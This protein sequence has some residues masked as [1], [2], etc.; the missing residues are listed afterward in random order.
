MTNAVLVMVSKRPLTRIIMIL[1]TIVVL[2]VLVIAFW[3]YLQGFFSSI[4]SAVLAT[5]SILIA[6]N[7]FEPLV[8]MLKPGKFAD[9]AHPMALM[10]L[11][12][13]V[14]IVLRLIFDSAVPGNVRVP[15]LV[16]KIGGGV[17]GVIV[18][19]MVAGLIA[20]GAQ[21]MPLGVTVAGYA[22]MRVVAETPAVVKINQSRSADRVLY[23]EM[24]SQTMDQEPPQ[25]LVIPADDFVVGLVSWISRGAASG[26]RPWSAIHPDYLTELFGNRI[27]IELG[28]KRSAQPISGDVASLTGV[29]TVASIP[30]MHGELPELRPDKLPPTLRP[31]DG[32]AILICRIQFGLD[33]TDTDRFTRVSCGTTRLVA[34][35]PNR[36]GQFKDYFPI[37]TV[38]N[39]NTLLVNKPD[40][41]LIVP[42]DK[43]VDFLFL[44]DRA[45][46]PDLRNLPAEVPANSSIFVESKRYARFS[47]ASKPIERLA[48][49]DT[50]EVMRKPA[51][52][53]NVST[54]DPKAGDRIIGVW[55]QTT[56]NGP[57]TFR[58]EANGQ[59]I[60]TMTI[61]GKENV[62][63]GS[64][65]VGASRLDSL[66]VIE[67]S[68]S[69]SEIKFTWTFKSPT[70][71]TVK[72]LQKNFEIQLTR[73]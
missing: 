38:A 69:G 18:G 55:V 56:A 3:H 42:A 19:L 32:Q 49:S 16:D 54:N 58:Y 35:V 57:V 72:D 45:V 14:Y 10:V 26:D 46:L 6:F 5:I 44:V 47:L 62:A 63:Q 23:D 53:K 40:D 21:G 50:V 52:L 65:K 36:P 20:V 8:T 51:V 31:E 9:S 43:A 24:V 29:Y 70:E 15:A 13:V 27:G 25:S 33:A 1:S 71:V 41:F 17:L 67:K 22:R 28:A 11:F 7:Y 4:I 59:L 48:A 68:P 39:G 73:Q 61:A 12:G 30:Q 60:R 64:W 66:D 34:P 2:L 37:G